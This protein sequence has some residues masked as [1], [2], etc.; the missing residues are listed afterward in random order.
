[1]YNHL[2][3]ACLL[4]LLLLGNVLFAQT[5]GTGKSRV[6]IETVYQDIDLSFLKNVM[7]KT[8]DYILLDVR[9][10]EEIANGKINDAVELDIRRPDFREELDKL[11]KNRLYIVYCHAGG[12][13]TTASNV[14]KELGFKQVYNFTQGYRVWQK[15]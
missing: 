6:I 8:K 2:K 1:M 14:M 10:P 15:E 4:C 9:T 5:S 11:D 12:R 7:S 3:F 13:S